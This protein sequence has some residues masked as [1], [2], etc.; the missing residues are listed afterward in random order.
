M[1][2]VFDIWMIVGLLFFVVD[3]GMVLG[4]LI[5]SDWILFSERVNKMKVVSKK[6][7][8]LIKGIILICVFLGFED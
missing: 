4:R 6:N 5:D 8:M 2:L 3:V 1:E 7:I